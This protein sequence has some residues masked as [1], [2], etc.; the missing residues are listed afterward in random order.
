MSGFE[1]FQMV[2]VGWIIGW[3]VKDMS[4][5]VILSR[6]RCI[7]ILVS[8]SDADGVSY[9]SDKSICRLI[10]MTADRLRKASEL[11]SCIMHNIFWLNMLKES[12]HLFMNYSG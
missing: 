5:I 7:Y 8:V 4:D 1:R 10:H 9:Y 6:W 12:A 2:S 11:T 3:Y